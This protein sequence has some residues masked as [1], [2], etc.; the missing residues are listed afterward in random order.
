MAN[1]IGKRTT[2]LL[3]V[4]DRLGDNASV[5][6]HFDTSSGFSIDIDVKEDGI[7]HIGVFLS[8]DSLKQT[9]NHLE[10]G[11]GRKDGR[12]LADDRSKGMS[13]QGTRR[14][15]QQNRLKKFHSRS[16]SSHYHF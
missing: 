14:D 5:Q 4:F 15:D 12:F 3:E 10:F 9:T 1:P 2:Y 11:G 6:T 8:K 13:V 7:R 16:S